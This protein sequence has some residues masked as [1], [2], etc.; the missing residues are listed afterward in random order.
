MENQIQEIRFYGSKFQV[1]NLKAMAELIN[2]SGLKDGEKPI[3]I[4]EIT[5]A[6][7]LWERV[8][9]LIEQFHAAESKL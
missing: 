4:A 9:E 5:K 8:Q 2:K 7:E 1:E 3:R 6:S